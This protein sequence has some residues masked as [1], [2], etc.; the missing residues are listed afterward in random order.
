MRIAKASFDFN[1]RVQQGYLQVIRLKFDEGKRLLDKEQQANPSNQLPILY[2]NYIDFLKAF[3]TEE[4]KDF[5]AFTHNAEERLKKIKDENSPFSQY[6]KAEIMLQEAMLRVKFREFVP[7]AWEIRKVYKLTEKNRA[8]YPSFPLNKKISGFLKV[9]IGAI[10]KDYH[11]L[12]DLAGMEGTIVQGTAELSKLL[13]ETDGSAYDVYQE[14]ILFYLTS[15]QGSFAKSDQTVNTVA[16]NMKPYCHESLLMRYCYSNV[17]M[18]TGRND[19]ALQVLSD[20]TS[21]KSFYPFYFLSYKAGLAKL[22]K[23]DYSGEKEFQNFLLH[24]KGINNIRAAYQKLAWIAL[25]KGDQKK[26]FYYMDL[27]KTLG[28]DLIDDD[29]DALFEAKE[30]DLPNL[31][32]LRSRLLFDGGYYKQALSEIAGKT[33][34]NFPR[35]KDQ[36]EVSYRFARI[37]QKINQLDK[38]IEYYQQTLKN[39]A[40][41]TYYFAAN[42]ALLLGNIY[43]ERNDFTKANYYYSHCLEMR[44]HDYQNSI[45]QKAQA[46]LERIKKK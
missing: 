14:E 28:T 41:S 13:K 3:I 44:N 38:A 22:R 36:L 21:S 19:E 7:A 8:A 23:L 17:L 31:I 37:L 1:E 11:W 4:K 12:T 10:P 24:F 43:E 46:G 20:T 33:N 27:C 34:D 26:Y 32:L 45:D 39:G 35:L 9:L 16:D 5:D 18:K 15:I 40:S 6:A 29:K 30:N 42:S 2:Y 25:L